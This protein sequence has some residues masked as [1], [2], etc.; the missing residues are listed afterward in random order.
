MDPSNSLAKLLV[1]TFLLA[2]ML[3]IGMNSRVTS[4]RRLLMSRGLLLRTLAANFVVVPLVGL[5][6]VRLLPL[7]PD[8]AAAILLLACVP[9]GLG[10]VQFTSRVKGEEALPGATIVL[11]NLGALAFSPALFRAVVPGGSGLA[12]P[13]GSLV[14]FFA[15]WVLVPLGIGGAFRETAPGVARRLAAPLGVL[16]FIAFIGFMVATRTYRREA[17]A[18]IDAPALGAMALLLVA[19][20]VAGW[21]LGGPARETRQLLATATGMRHAAF[22]LAMARSAPGAAAVIPPLAVFITLMVPTNMLFTFYGAIRARSAARRA[23]QV[24]VKERAA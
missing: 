14:G 1:L 17:L 23:G 8:A 13:Y 19:S 16:G 10:S 11:L 6:L 4:L 24:A 2:T 3:S 15:L 5:L 7:R 20:M 18:S 21:L 22:C 12:L 9:G